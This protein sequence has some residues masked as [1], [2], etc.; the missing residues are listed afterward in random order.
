MRNRLE[1]AKLSMGISGLFGMQWFYLGDRSKAAGRILCTLLIFTLF[2][3]MIMSL[4]EASRFLSMSQ[5]E[6]D[7]LY[8]GGKCSDVPTLLGGDQGDNSE[9]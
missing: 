5:E 9:F 4:V 3:S 1:A 2:I 7:N 8:N 6:F